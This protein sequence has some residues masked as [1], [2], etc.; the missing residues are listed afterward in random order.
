MKRYGLFLVLGAIFGFTLSRAG[1]THYDIISDMFRFKNPQLY[2][3]IGTAFVLNL[4]AFQVM[5]RIGVSGRYGMPLNL[6]DRVFHPGVIP[7]AA[8]FGIGWAIT[9]ICPGTAMAQLG[10]GHLAAL[11]TVAGVFVGAWIYPRVHAR[12]FDWQ[13]SRCGE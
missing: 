9:G 13:A 8:I 7:G 11:V 5:R 3:V 10:E 12:Y 6:P 4:V 2:F 1:A